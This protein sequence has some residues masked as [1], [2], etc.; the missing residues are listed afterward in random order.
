MCPQEQCHRILKKYT[1]I[2]YFWGLTDGRI[3]SGTWGLS[4]RQNRSDVAVKR[5][6]YG[7]NNSDINVYIRELILSN[8]DRNLQIYSKID[9]GAE[10]FV[11]TVKRAKRE[12]FNIKSVRVEGMYLGVNL[13]QQGMIVKVGNGINTRNNVVAKLKEGQHQENELSEER[14]IDSDSDNDGN[15]ESDDEDNSDDDASLSDTDSHND[16]SDDSDDDNV[17]EDDHS[18]DEANISDS[19]DNGDD[20]NNQD[21]NNRDDVNNGSVDSATSEEDDGESS[22]EDDDIIFLSPGE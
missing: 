8:K 9:F 17:D 6:F 2:E 10:V 14:G 7:D 5:V 3:R 11:L 20:A 1:K 22:G 15:D 16:N 12:R 4:D 21:D 19:D 18:D 13:R